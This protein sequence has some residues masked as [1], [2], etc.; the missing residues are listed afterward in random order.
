[1]LRTR[2]KNTP[3]QFLLPPRARGSASA[4]DASPCHLSYGATI[5]MA[6]MQQPLTQT[7]ARAIN[8]NIPV[9]Y[10]TILYDAPEE[11][12]RILTA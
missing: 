7:S 3:R 1:M 8:I 5:V 4:P 6:Y 9:R 2:E 12:D 10:H 11:K